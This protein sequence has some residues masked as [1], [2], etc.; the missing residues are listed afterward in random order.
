MRRVGPVSI[1]LLLAGVP[2]PGE[3]QRPAPA[4][5]FAVSTERVT[6]DFIVRDK[7]DGILRGLTPA[8]VEVYEDGVKQHVESL[9]FVERHAAAESAAIPAPPAFVAVAFD[10]L[11]PAAR[12][13]AR[14][15]VLDYLDSPAA[16][17]AWTG[18]FSI[19]RSLS[20]LHPFTTERDALRQ[21]LDR[22]V[23]LSP[24]SF[25]GV[26]ERDVVRKAYGGLATGFGQTHIASA[27]FSAEPECRDAEDEVVRRLKILD[28]RLVESFDAFERNQQGFAT[29]HALLALISA[30]ETLPGR[31]AVLLFSEGLAIPA[32]VE[33]SFASVVAAANRANVSIYGAD[34]GGLRAASGADETRRTIASLQTR[35][36]LQQG[37]GSPPSRG[38]STP[39][40]PTSGLVLLE[41]NENT[42]R[43]APGSGLGRLADATG[44][45]L[46]HESNDL[47]TGLAQMAE[48][49][50]AYYQLSYAPKNQT[51]D[52]RFRAITV[53]LRRS[54]GRLQ[55]RKGYLAVRTPLPMPALDYEAL[56]L[57]QLDKDHPPHAVPLHV[58]ALQFPEEP[59]L[60]LVPIL[61]EVP[62]GGHQDL[63][64]VVL[65]RDTSRQVVATMSQRY[66]DAPRPV[67]FY[68]EAS[69]PPGSYTLEAVAHD[70]RSGAAGTATATLEVPPASARQLRASSLMVVAS[71]EPLGASGGA[72]AKPFRYGDVLLHPHLGQPLRLADRRPLA[73]FVTAWP[74]LERPRL[75]ARIEVTRGGNTVAT[76]RS[77]GL[78]PGADGR[79]QLASSLS[80]EPFPP[81]V[82]EL[83][84]TLTDGEHEE[85][86]TAVVPIAP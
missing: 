37:L 83:R 68:R 55:A 30:L 45:F 41:R 5:A 8:D 38:A 67:L 49:L 65:L 36:E 42:L 63:T 72:T 21:A 35:L 19:D 58:R 78:R 70:A 33:A 73:F 76:T 86:R 15:A 22:S 9:A 34:A 27:E 29:T 60:S 28:S 3:E 62:A 80:L 12:S 23:L 10:R 17:P 20:T 44:G 79:I 74:V 54:H 43:L 32:D 16:A 52:G 40:D 39:E 7:K 82:Y 4:P 84:V 59:P 69:L 13:F 56:A 11:S 48:E 57:G 75:D 66:A 46:I 31:K 61:V 1:V 26:R 6:V 85:T 25:T 64:I 2:L 81:G 14:Q 51:Y 18:L 77:R 24:T 50:G 71:A 47:S 53:K